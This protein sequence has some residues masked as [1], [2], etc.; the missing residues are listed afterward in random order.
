MKTGAFIFPTTQWTAVVNAAKSDEAENR[1]DALTALCREYWMPLY[2]F[3]RRLGND[4]HDAQDL[5]QGFFAFL[6]ERD[7]L[8]TANRDLGTLRT[9]LLRVFQRYISDVQDREHAQKRGGG[10]RL[11]SLDITEGEHLADTVGAGTETPEMLYDRA[12][13]HSVL[14]GALQKL[15]AIEI[16]AGRE[17]MFSVL[18]P[19]LNPDSEQETSY[20]GAAAHLDMTTEAVRQAVS[21][22]RKK[23]RD[24]LRERIAAT[25]QEPDD[26]RIDEE[27]HALKAALRQ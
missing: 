4:R 16:A 17:L 12:W 7:V 20:E 8:R 19:R 3:S 2:A 9:F 25:L 21:R 11:C 15:R 1:Q 23:F 10:V 27:L 13:A 26:A 18:E 14:R 6:L 24:C 22:L 5:T